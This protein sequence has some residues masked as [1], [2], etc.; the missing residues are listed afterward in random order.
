MRKHEIH[1][2]TTMIKDVIQKSI[3]RKK[4]R[5]LEDIMFNFLC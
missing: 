2:Y 4:N 3:E 1:L 5:Y